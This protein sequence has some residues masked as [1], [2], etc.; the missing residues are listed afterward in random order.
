MTF[1][2]HGITPVPARQAAK[3]T[4][5]QDNRLCVAAWGK[6]ADAYPLKAASHRAASDAEIAH[7]HRTRH[8][9]TAEM[10]RGSRLKHG[11]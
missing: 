10:V 5:A 4:E 8:I 6:A 2:A 1:A 7:Y 11:Q 3:H 9:Q